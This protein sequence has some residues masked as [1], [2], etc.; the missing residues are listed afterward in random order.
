MK[1]RK[2]EI[3]P[4]EESKARNRITWGKNKRKDI[5]CLYFTN[6]VSTTRTTAVVLE[7]ETNLEY[8]LP[9][10]ELI[11][12][13]IKPYNLRLC[14]RERLRSYVEQIRTEKKKTK[15]GKGKE[16]RDN[17]NHKGCWRGGSEASCS[18]RKN[19]GRAY[20]NLDSKLA[21]YGMPTTSMYLES[22][23]T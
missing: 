6:Q 14:D 18:T 12:L 22:Y 10:H 17:I 11:W 15:T 4:P 23:E 19:S 9:V 21:N 8:L 16:W 20:M 1:L 5:F 2:Y 13:R 3:T 7:T